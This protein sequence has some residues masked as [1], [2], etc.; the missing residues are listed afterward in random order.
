MPEQ[1]FGGDDDSSGSKPKPVA[2]KKIKLDKFGLRPDIN[3][4]DVF[5]KIMASYAA[6]KKPGMD[7]FS[8]Q[9]E[10]YSFIR[11]SLSAISDPGS[12]QY[13]LAPKFIAQYTMMMLIDAKWED[14]FTEFLILSGDQKEEA[15]AS[16][17]L[18]LKKLI[19]QEEYREVTI[20]TFAGILRGRESVGVALE[21]IA[22]M[23]SVQLIEAVKKELVIVA[24]GDIGE[25]QLNAI[26]AIKVI[27]A[28]PEVKKSF[29][30]LLS[31]WDMETRMA[32]VEA[33]EPLKTDPEIRSAIEKRLPLE[34][35]EK[36]KTELAK[37]LK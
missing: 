35:N 3:P 19:E 27:K 6:T 33:L 7:L 12:E 32:T 29:I 23:E 34:T 4:R 10:M 17:T 28:D 30:V 20:H 16:I 1:T 5:W 22:K 37:L 36:I 31:H 13:G 11:I 8:L 26:K 14:G 9:N 24:R 21:Y 18:G 2:K 25:N 15:K